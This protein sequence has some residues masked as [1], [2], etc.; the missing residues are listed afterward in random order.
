[1]RRHRSGGLIQEE[2]DVAE[3]V[4][5][6][7]ESLASG[8]CSIDSGHITRSVISGDT[9]ISNSRV[10]SSILNCRRV[11]DSFVWASHLKSRVVVRSS[12]IEQVELHGPIMVENATLIGPWTLEHLPPYT[13]YLRIHGTWE[14]PPRFLCGSQYTIVECGAGRLHIGCKCRTRDYWLKHYRF[15]SRLGE[16]AEAIKQFILSL[17]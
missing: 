13:D 10:S 16:D 14:R 7:R 1:M 3:C 15:G 6:D 8:D 17:S 4:E 11:T 5:I 9:L 12:H 2:A